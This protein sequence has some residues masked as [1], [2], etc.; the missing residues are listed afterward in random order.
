MLGR[1][2]VGPVGHGPPGPP[3]ISPGSS[4]GPRTPWQN[5]GQA[6][7]KRLA[8]SHQNPL[9][10]DLVRGCFTFLPASGRSEASLWPAGRPTSGRPPAGGR[11]EAIYISIYLFILWLWSVLF[12]VTWVCLLIETG[13]FTH[14]LEAIV[15]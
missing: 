14:M 13:T 5:I 12:H 4:Q 7:L 15:T 1:G 11:P 3:K 10:F 8:N 6:K 2:P 9:G